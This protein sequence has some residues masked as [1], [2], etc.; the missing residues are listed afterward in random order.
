MRFRRQRLSSVRLPE[1]PPHI[2]DEEKIVRAVKT[3]HHVKNGKLKPAA[4]RPTVGETELSCMRQL[5][6][7]DVCKNK[8]VEICGGSE[9]G[10]VGLSAVEARAVRAVGS[11]V[12]D[13]PEDFPGHAHMV[14]PFP[15]PSANNPA[16]A[17]ENEAAVMHYRAI[18]NA[19]MFYEDPNPDAL[20]WLGPPM[21]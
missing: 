7:D 5:I 12:I 2:A 15:A 1:L 9:N 21:S 4:Y 16:Q 14:H 11:E 18:A 20:G 13:K 8:A 3:P 17:K 10:Y 19:A 6:G